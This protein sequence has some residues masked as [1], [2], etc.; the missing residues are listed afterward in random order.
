MN[1]VE[2]DFDNLF[3]QLSKVGKSYIRVNN[4]TGHIIE[5]FN[6]DM[7]QT[8]EGMGPLIYYLKAIDGKLE[9]RMINMKR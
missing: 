2:F 6:S 7:S 4:E 8:I 9:N 1:D 3:E 5:E